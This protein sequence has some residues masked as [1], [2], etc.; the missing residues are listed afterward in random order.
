MTGGSVR[1]CGWA[2]R[3]VLVRSRGEGVEDEDG[4]QEVGLQWRV[5][6]CVLGE[7]QLCKYL[8][9]ALLEIEV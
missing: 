5:M 8:S 7:V 4:M 3:I 9:L 6:G 2:G 1:S